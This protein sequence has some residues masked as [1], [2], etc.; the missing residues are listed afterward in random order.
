MSFD[1]ESKRDIGRV[2]NDETDEWEETWTGDFIFEN[3]WQSFSDEEG[4]NAG[5]D[6]RCFAIAGLGVCDRDY[7]GRRC[8]GEADSLCPGLIC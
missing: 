7:P 8:A 6:Q 3:E 1:F 4:S 5:V 2:N